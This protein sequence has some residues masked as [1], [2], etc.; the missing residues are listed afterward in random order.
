HRHAAGGALLPAR[1]HPALRAAATAGREIGPRFSL[2]AREPC[3]SQERSCSRRDFRWP[4]CSLAAGADRPRQMRRPDR[5]SSPPAGGP[6]LLHADDKP[7]DVV[8]KAI[9]AYGGRDAMKRWARGH[10]RYRSKGTALPS[11]EAVEAVVGEDFDYP[12]RFK[13]IARSR[14]DGAELTL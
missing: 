12:G 11:P 9:E 4:R 14:K 6:A 7:A 1:R 2:R 10:V 5:S 13:R 3:G 8:R